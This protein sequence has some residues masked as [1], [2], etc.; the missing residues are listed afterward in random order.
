M[1]KNVFGQS[2]FIKKQIIR[3]FGLLSYGRFNWKNT[4]DIQ[5]SERLTELPESNVLLVSNHQTYFADVALMHHAIHSALRGKIDNVRH[6][7]FLR[8]K[9]NLY[10]VAADETMK[11]GLL[12]RFMSL[13]GTIQVKRTWR[14]DG[15][16]VKRD[17]D[18]KDTDNI[19]LALKDGW[20][21]SFPQGTTKPFMPGRKGTAHLIKQHKPIVVP[22]V[23]NGFRRAFDRKGF[24]IKKKGTTLSMWFKPPL[25]I[26]YDAPVDDILH[27]VMH[28]I[29]QT[30][31]HNKVPPSES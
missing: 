9:H 21:I 10:I 26:D 12:P 22:I 23:I 29:E 13:A 2:I 27:Q 6:P 18:L 31:Q 4:T 17:V 1:A 14:K 30:E 20:V 11:D 25:Q 8:P 28:A 15:E 5:G 16:D 7:G 19:G 24:F 3:L